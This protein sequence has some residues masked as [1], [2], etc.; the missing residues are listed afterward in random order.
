[1]LIDMCIEIFD[2]FFELLMNF[3]F[4]MVGGCFTG[5]GL[6]K[7]DGFDG[8]FKG[9]LIALSIKQFKVFVLIVYEVWSEFMGEGQPLVLL[10]RV[11]FVHVGFL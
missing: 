4:F 3:D 11:I 5:F 6:D 7:D 9:G 1:M 8:V 2:D 10:M